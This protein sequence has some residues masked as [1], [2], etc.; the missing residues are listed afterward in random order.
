MCSL[1]L[2]CE[3]S[4]ITGFKLET[5]RLSKPLILRPDPPICAMAG[6]KDAAPLLSARVKGAGLWA[7]DSPTSIVRL[8]LR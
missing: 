2:A 8:T 5:A 4:R 7:G 3:Y 6:L 1:R